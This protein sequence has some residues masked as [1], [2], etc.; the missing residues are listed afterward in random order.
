ML[1]DAASLAQVAPALWRA[2][3][4]M[5]RLVGWLAALLLLPAAGAHAAEAIERY[6]A[7]IEVRRDGDLAVTETITVR[8]EGDRIQRGIY[9]DFPLRFRDAEGRLRQVSFELVDVER[10]GLPEPHHTSRNDRGVR[11][12]VGREDVLLAPGRYTYRLRYL[13]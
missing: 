12:Y 4:F 5:L 10:D 13:T 8:A 3:S 11:I 7:T 2:A 1:R 9:R 6:D